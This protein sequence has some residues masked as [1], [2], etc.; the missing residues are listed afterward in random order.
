[1]FP[2]LHDVSVLFDVPYTKTHPFVCNLRDD[3][4]QL[5]H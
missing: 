1:M 4:F 5:Q 2:I 3:P